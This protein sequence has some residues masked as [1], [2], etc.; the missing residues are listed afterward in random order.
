MADCAA[1]VSGLIGKGAQ[2]KRG[3]GEKQRSHEVTDFMGAMA[4]LLSDAERGVTRQRYKGLGE[5]NPEQLWETTMDIKQRTM[6]KVQIDDG[7]AADNIFITLM[8]DEVEP[9]RAFIEANALVAQNI[10]F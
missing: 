1:T 2:I 5:M 8:G 9:R 3:E 7:I 6:L 10:D 4:W